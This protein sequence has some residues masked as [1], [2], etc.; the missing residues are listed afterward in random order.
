MQQPTTKRGA[1]FLDRDGTI[2]VEIDFIHRVEDLQLLPNAVAGL[3]RMVALGF[4]LYLTTNQSGIGRGYFTEA[5]MNRFNVALCAQLA[6]HAI[7]IAGIYVCP[8]HP[9]KGIGP[10]KQDSQLRKPKPGMILEAAAEH[11]IDLAASI[12][13]GDR[14]SDVAAGHA[15]GCRT[16]LVRTGQAGAD[17]MDHVVP[18]DFIA[19]DLLDAARFI[20]RARNR[21]TS[22][23]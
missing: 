1:I 8:F 21:V 23:N 11:A 2:N 20:E 7:T 15:A 12:A 17:K 18:P 16:I 4:Q 3:Q 5:D 22:G 9:T 6:V 19:N 14:N 10:Y 13:I